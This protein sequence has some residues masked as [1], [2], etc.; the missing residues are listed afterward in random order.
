MNPLYY[1]IKFCTSPRPTTRKKNDNF[2]NF[3]FP[4]FFLL[5]LEKQI[6]KKGI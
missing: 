3:Y 6:W 2:G 4:Y 5:N 1:T